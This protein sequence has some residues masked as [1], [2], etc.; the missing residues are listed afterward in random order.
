MLALHPSG[1]PTSAASGSRAAFEAAQLP[2]DDGFPAAL[3]ASAQRRP[4]AARRDRPRLR[5]RARRDRD[6]RADH[7][8]RRDHAGAP[9]R[10]HRATS[11]RTLTRSDRL[12]LTRPRASCGSSSTG[13]R[14]CTAAGWSRRARLTTLF[15]RP[16]PSVHAHVAGGDSRGSQARSGL[17]GIPGSAVEPSES[18]GGCPYAPRLRVPPRRLRDRAC[19]P[20]SRRRRRARCAAGTWPL[21]AGADRS[22]RSC[23][24]TRADEPHG[25]PAPRLGSRARSPATAA[26]ERGAAGGARD[27]RAGGLVRRRRGAVPRGRRREWQRQDD[28]CALHRRPARAGGGGDHVRRSSRS[29]RQPERS[30]EAAPAIQ[31]V[32]QD[33][34]SSLNPSM[35]VGQT[36][37]RPLRRSSASRGGAERRRRR[38]AARACPPPARPRGCAAAS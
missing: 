32:F 11:A 10:R 19:L 17:R 4:E 34:D 26:V 31:I 38:R 20:R 18:A 23:G 16:A 7:R 15:E 6:G 24:E 21:D 2:T 22:R 3:P 27:R 1:P 5:L 8:P 30:R 28:A 33:P 36:I 14:S 12:R 37:G 9:A 13:S 35:T 25:D 29:G